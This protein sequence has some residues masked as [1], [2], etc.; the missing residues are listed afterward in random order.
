MSAPEIPP[1]GVVGDP[2]PV[3]SPVTASVASGEGVTDLEL[4]LRND[5][6]PFN[7]PT[8]EEVILGVDA[9][10]PADGGKIVQ[11]LW[12]KGQGLFRVV[13]TTPVSDPKNHPVILNNNDGSQTS[14]LPTARPLATRGRGMGGGRRDGI[15]VTFRN[16]NLGSNATIPNEHF[17]KV[18]S[19]L[20]EVVKPTMFQR[21]RNTTTFNGNRYCVVD[22]GEKVVPAT[23]MVMN[24]ANQRLT[25][26]QTRYKGQKWRCGR[27]GIDHV[28]GCE[29][30]K[31]FYA[32]KEVRDKER[33]DM[34]ILSDS[35]LR[36]AEQV[37]LRADVLCMTGAGVGHL[38][39][40]L[41]D[42]PQIM[43]REAVGV[44]LGGNDITN[45][46]EASPAEFV[47]AVDKGVGRLKVELERYAGKT[48]AVFSPPPGPNDNPEDVMRAQYLRTSLEAIQSER[49]STHVLPPDVERDDTGHPTEEGTKTLLLS[50]RD[51]VKKD[52]VINDAF[53][54]AGKLYGGVQ[55]VFCYGCRT[56][57]KVGQFPGKL[58]IC[59]T[60]QEDIGR[61]DGGERWTKFV[62]SLPPPPPLLP[63]G[64]PLL[65][66]PNNWRG[67]EGGGVVEKRPRADDSGEEG[68]NCTKVHVTEARPQLQDETD[69]L[70]G[71]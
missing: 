40:A 45:S 32:A 66:D 2:V 39:N 27:C 46:E 64:P 60:C 29:K 11:P 61:Y 33:I 16:A 15:L 49:I 19:N 63:P 43:D 12:G 1:P 18:M 10:F 8:I 38:A 4:S 48:L 13:L 30:L 41:R 37:G 6:T 57:G 14:I 68:A 26:I 56:C 21:T 22:V 9:A 67:V 24:P 34:K 69:S 58:G 53:M 23:I 44:V 42:D 50:I 47:Y 54:V 65:I 25:P 62:A 35:T 71:T 5:F 28:G 70:D 59:H 20:G 51:E 52:L 17:D 36:Q 3:A 55:S 7:L 31:E